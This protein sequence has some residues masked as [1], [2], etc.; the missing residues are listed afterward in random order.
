MLG[1][2]IIYFLQWRSSGKLNSPF[3]PYF[4]QQILIF[5]KKF[6]PFEKE[7]IST[8]TFPKLNM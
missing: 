2:K 1:F 4:F 3:Y 7:C 5:L 6:L 8:R